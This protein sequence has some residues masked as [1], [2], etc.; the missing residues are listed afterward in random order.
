MIGTPTWTGGFVEEQLG[1]VLHT[2]AL[3]PIPLADLVGLALRRNPRRAHLLVSTVLAKHVPTDPDLVIAAGMTLGVLVG[4]R[5]STSFAGGEVEGAAATAGLLRQLGRLLNG[6]DHDGAGATRLRSALVKHRSTHP[7]V[8]TI[9]YAET[10]T[11]LGRHVADVIGSYYVH[12]TRHAPEGSRAAAAFEEAHS[13]ATSHHLLADDPGWLREGGSVVLVDDELTSGST[14]V[15]TIRVLQSLVP[16]ASWLIAALVDLRSDADRMRFDALAVELGTSI[17]VVSLSAGTV[18]LP[19]DTAE[20]AAVLIESLPPVAANTGPLAS[21][22]VLDL[23]GDVS[24][25]R[26]DRFGGRP[27]DRAEVLETAAMIAVTIAAA[28]GKTIGLPRADSVSRSVLV[29]GTEEFMAL[30][31]DVASRLRGAKFSTTTRSPI[32]ALDRPDYAVAT[33]VTF[34]SHDDTLDGPG[35]RFA[36]NLARNG[37]RFDD[38]VVMPEP[39]TDMALMTGPG[40]LI[41]ALRPLC[42]RVIVVVLASASPSDPSASPHQRS[43]L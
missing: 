14:V 7:D 25:V 10:A 41:E 30:P 2:D 23:A 6:S 26:S 15:N 35:R 38:I 20:R 40:G 28:I 32:A 4:D 22:S 12:S 21:V 11:A 27:G 36:Y 5:L 39:G 34:R 13:H 42:E 24:P 3:S 43:R 18:E 8:V 19:D 16:Q 37:Q 17:S 33:A 9:G 29:L 31:L 1:I